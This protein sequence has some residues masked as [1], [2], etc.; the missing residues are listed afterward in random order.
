MKKLFAKKQL[1]MVTLVAA[2]GVAVYLNYYLTNDPALSAGANTSESD[3]QPEGDSLGQATFVDAP[4]STKPS[5]GTTSADEPTAYF[6][7]ARKNRTTAREE[8]LSI[9]QEVLDNAK[10]T[11]ED[12]AAA[13]KQAAAIAQNVLQESNIENLIVAKGFG[14]SVVFIDGDRCSVVVQ[15][16][17]LQQQ[18]SLQILEIVVSQA[19]VAPEKVQIVTAKT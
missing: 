10:S 7:T 9:L 5:T 1:L 4:V 2:L 17:E 14:D 12:K 19:G 16:E 18:E 11:A 15:A 6:D 13:T 3:T 8:A